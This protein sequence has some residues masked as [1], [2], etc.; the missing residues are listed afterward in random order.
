MVER[1]TSSATDLRP[2]GP[3]GGDTVRQITGVVRCWPS[4]ARRGTQAL[5]LC[6]LALLSACSLTGERHPK[7][8]GSSEAADGAPLAEVSMDD[9]FSND[10]TAYTAVVPRASVPP[11]ALDD[12]APESYTVIKGDTLWDISDRFLKKPWLWPTI[13]NYNPQIANPHLIYPGDRIALEYV[14]GKPT[15]VLSRNGKRLPLNGS[16]RSAGTGP[17]TG[18]QTERLSPR[19]RVESLDDAVPTIPGESIQQFLVHPRV[20]AASEIEAAPYVVAHHDDRLISAVG[21]KVY[22]R[23]LTSRDETQYAVFRRSKTLRDPVTREVLGY[24]VTHVADARLL[25][26]GDP[27]TLA[28]TRNRM[29]TIAGDILLPAG[30]EQAN[31]N[32]VPRLPA[33]RGEGRIVSLVNA[34]AKTGRDQV[35]VLNLGTRSGIQPGDILAIESRGG[36]MVDRRGKGRFERIR[37]PDYRSGV[38]MVFQAFDKVSYALVMESTRPV[39]VNDI[40]TGL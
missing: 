12:D 3:A 24:E 28:I 20:V 16:Q 26:L 18:S 21:H 25:N 29:E 14:N 30:M 31:Y 39:M 36:S 35:V 37:L 5:L 15:L 9:R 40:I 19:I 22:A 4:P 7:A 2:D 27:S 11:E 10:T 23:G 13:W 38:V 33:I 17:D 6:S 32:Y 8:V 1:S 34:I